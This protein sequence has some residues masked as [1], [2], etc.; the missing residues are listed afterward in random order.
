VPL[1]ATPLN[2]PIGDGD[3]GIVIKPD[4]SVQFFTC[5]TWPQSD[6]DLTEQQKENLDLLRLLTIVGASSE[7]QTLLV[8][9]MEDVKQKMGSDPFEV[10]IDTG[11]SH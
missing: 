2:A 9:V 5:G 11:T 4:G 6:D 8:K 1:V 3:V 7:I 10:Q